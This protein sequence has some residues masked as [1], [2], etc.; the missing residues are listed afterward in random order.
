[1]GIAMKHL[2]PTIHYPKF[3]QSPAAKWS[4]ETSQQFPQYIRFYC[5]L[6]ISSQQYG[7]PL[8]LCSMVGRYFSE[9]PFI[10]VQVKNL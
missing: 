1:M 10:I 3:E 5:G 7:L 2:K 4:C 8:H 9:N 6:H